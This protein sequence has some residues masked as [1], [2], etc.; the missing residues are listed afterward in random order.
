[1]DS[2][3]DDAP[4]LDGAR[5]G[6]APLRVLHVSQPTVA[7][8]PHVVANLVRDQ[9]AWGWHVSVACPPTGSLPDL[10]RAEGATH[11]RWPATRQPG[12]R[13]LAETVRLG[14]LVRSVAPHVVH[15]HS[16]KAG[17][18]GRLA[19]RGGRC[20]LFQPHGWSFDALH[21]PLRTAARVWERNGAR[22]ADAVVC[23][24]AGERQRGIRAGVSADLRLIPNG[25][26]LA[27]WPPAGPD[28]REAA[29]AAL[30]LP[31]GPLVV[32]V[33]RLSRAKGQDLLLDAWPGVLRRIP[34]AQL[35]LV[36][37]GPN[38]A[39]LRRRRIPQVRMAL[40]RP[41]VAQWLTAADVVA[42]PSRWEGM[43]LV[44]LE[45]M[46]VGRSVVASDAPG[47]WELL[48]TDAGAVV[49]QGD[50]HGLATAL[51]DRLLDRNRVSAEE[52]AARDRVQ[53]LHGRE[54]MAER[55]RDLYGELL[56]RRAARGG[57]SRTG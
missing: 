44:V 52:R 22:W 29:R 47:M 10:I 38:R 21:G 35:V 48:G 45:A 31:E 39:S 14:R 25:I 4:S 20:T 1:M 34:E 2:R 12:H 33:G 15:L 27:S 43:S 36:G 40:D 49:P 32:C 50:L 5:K 24:S 23:V 7:G 16:S 17:L 28:G 26:D 42:A 37:D 57:D 41:D 13:S 30:R 54:V 6:R 11:L 19:V 56:E 55:I 3:S 53:Q 8:V 46:A 9:V 18:A 51:V